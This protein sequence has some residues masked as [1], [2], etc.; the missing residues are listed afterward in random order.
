MINKFFHLILVIMMF[1]MVY[2]IIFLEVLPYKNGDKI[3]NNI[4]FSYPLGFVFGIFGLYFLYLFFTFK[5]QKQKYTI[6]PNCQE[7]YDYKNLD[8]GK[9]KYCDN[10]DTVDI[11]KYYKDNKEK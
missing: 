10:V 2:S 5:P 4:Y 3:L 8:N 6:C 1:Y 7:S 9:C 11:E